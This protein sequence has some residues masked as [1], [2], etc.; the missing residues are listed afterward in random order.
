MGFKTYEHHGN[1][2]W[3]DED[4]KG[5]HRDHCLCYSCSKFYPLQRDEN[6]Q[7][8][9]LVYATCVALK[10]TLPVWECPYFQEK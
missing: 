8:S 4:L 5:K 3:V 1:E 9:N 10:L 7:I 2:V 6:C